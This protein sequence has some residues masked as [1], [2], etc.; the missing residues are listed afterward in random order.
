MTKIWATCY[1]RCATRSLV[2]FPVLIDEFI[3]ELAGSYCFSFTQEQVAA[4]IERK[5]KLV[6]YIFLESRCEVNEHV[7]AQYKVGAGERCTPIQVVVPE[8]DHLPQRL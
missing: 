8:Y 2:H 5:S 7:A 3:I 4:R 1:G 6:E